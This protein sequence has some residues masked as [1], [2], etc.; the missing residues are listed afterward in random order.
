MDDDQMPVN[1]HLH[2]KFQIICA[3]GDGV[4]EGCQGIFWGGYFP[5]AMGNEIGGGW[6]GATQN[7]I[8]A[9]VEQDQGNGCK[10][11]AASAW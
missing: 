7:K 8:C 9:L 2:V 4:T 1:G 5:P 11:K 6:K 3:E 10:Q